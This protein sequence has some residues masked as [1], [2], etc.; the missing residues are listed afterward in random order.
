MADIVAYAPEAPI[1]TTTF[2]AIHRRT[3]E[4]AGFL[5][6]LGG[7][8]LPQVE[9]DEDDLIADA[10]ADHIVALRDRF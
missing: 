9:I 2:M 6:F 8:G 3:S 4:P 10:L 1:T 7:G 5:S